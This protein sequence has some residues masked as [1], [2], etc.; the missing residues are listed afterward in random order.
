[1]KTNLICRTNN[2]GNRTA[3]SINKLTKLTT[4]ILLSLTL[5]L[6]LFTTL[7][8]TTNQALPTNP[9]PTNNTNLEQPGDYINFPFVI[10]TIQSTTLPAC[11]FQ[12]EVWG[13]Q[14]GSQGAGR[15]G[16]VGGYSTGL[17]TFN[18]PTEVF[19]VVGGQGWNASPTGGF[20]GGGGVTA[21]SGSTGGGATHMSLASGMLNNPVVRDDILIVAGG[22]GGARN[23]NGTGGWGG[24]LVGGSGGMEGTAIAGGGTQT[25][26][27]QGVTGGTSGSAGQGGNGITANRAA[28]GGGWFGGGGGGTTIH[29][30]TGSVGGA[31]GSGFVSP[32]LT[33]TQ[34]IPG[35]Q[36]M[37]NPNGGTMVGRTGNGFARITLL[38]CPPDPYEILSIR[39]ELDKTEVTINSTPPILTVWGIQRNGQ[40]VV[41]LTT[42]FTY[43]PTITTDTLGTH[44][45]TITHNNFDTINPNNDLITTVTYTVIPVPIPPI[46]N[47][48]NPDPP[49]PSPTNPTPPNS[50]IDT[51]LNLINNNRTLLTLI[52]ITITA[53]L[54]AAYLAKRKLY[55]KR[56][57]YRY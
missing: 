7:I 16:G 14:G 32:T 25:S 44:T 24:G 56:R 27:G 53:S 35:N 39:A 29:A 34:L 17:V 22:G 9:V 43:T 51:L 40:E 46:P 21:G 49:I 11:T 23:V 2:K 33:N 28:G 50:G 8:P 26:G 31:G 3:R 20:N 38:E 41:L 19:V 42:D 18:D 54:A 48:N 37:P 45:I 52:A 4:S 5:I 12:L 30:A 57:L 6:G 15:A 36:T 55:R 13:A 10:G 1:M 47:P